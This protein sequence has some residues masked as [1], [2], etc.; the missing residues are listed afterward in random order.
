MRKTILWLIM[1]GA[2]L[3]P[4]IGIGLWWRNHHLGLAR[5]CTVETGDIISGV[6]VS[7]SIRSRQRAAVAAE[8]IAAVKALKVKE[9]QEVAAGQALIE[10]DSGVVEGELAKAQASVE[11][12]AQKLAQGEAG[13]RK[14][15]IDKAQKAING[16]EANLLYARKDHERLVKASQGG[17]ATPNELDQA[18]NRLRK[19]E[20]ELGSAEADL[21]L[22]KAG[23]RKEEIARAKAEVTLAKAELQR[24][25]ALVQK[26]TLRAPHAGIVTVKYVNEGEVVSP[27]QVLLRID[28]VK[29]LEVR[30]QVQEGQLCG[31]TVG[32]RGRVLADAHPE[33]PLEAVV[34]DILPRVDPEQGAITVLLKLVNPPPVRL[35]DGMAADIALIGKEVKGAVRVP[36]E[37]VEGKGEAASVRVRRGDSF[38]RR[39]VTTGLT[40]GHW[41]E[42]TSGL[43][44]GEVI[45]LP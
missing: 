21:A 27:G 38:V 40:D 17:V 28:S 42:I 34:E 2:V 33:T 11:I 30:A 32:G 16:A 13:A 18:I 43:K 14:E 7:G 24:L 39:P 6:I 22:L 3:G 36:A 12:A 23:A 45:R 4:A 1:L 25:S 35:M 44:A 8:I 41:V 5:T 26:Y 20:A 31:V 10:M 29:D 9:G 19:A 15:E 37:A